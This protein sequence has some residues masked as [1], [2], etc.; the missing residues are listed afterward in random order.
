MPLPKPER[1]LAKMAQKSPQVWFSSAGYKRKPQKQKHKDLK[2]NKIVFSN[3]KYYMLII[4][5]F[6]YRNPFVYWV[7]TEYISYAVSEL[8]KKN[9]T[10]PDVTRS[11]RS[12]GSPGVLKNGWSSALEMIS[13]CFIVS[14]STKKGC[15]GFSVGFVSC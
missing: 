9:D 6:T 12:G 10:Q 4:S 14:V 11:I 15:H 1:P 7:Y 13:I 8:W 3:K 5:T 2:V